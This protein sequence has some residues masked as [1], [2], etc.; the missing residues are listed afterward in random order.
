MAATTATS[1]VPE[2]SLVLDVANLGAATPVEVDTV[3]AWTYA[4]YYEVLDR[5]DHHRRYADD[6]RTR[7]N[8]VDA[9]TYR[10]A[11][12]SADRERDEVGLAKQD[13]VIAELTAQ[14]QAV[15][16]EAVPYEAEYERRGRWTRAFLVQ[17]SNG[18]V[19][20][21]RS[22]S[23][24]YPTTRYHWIL[25]FSGSTEQDVVAA[26]RASA[27]TECYP[28]APVDLRSQPSLIE[29]P[30]KAAARA[31]RAQAKAVRDAAAA[32]KAIANPDGSTLKTSYG[33]I[34]TERTAE[35]EYVSTAADIR[36]WQPWMNQE[37]L[38]RRQ[39]DAQRILEALAHKRGTTTAQQE[40]ALAPKVEKKV[41][42]SNR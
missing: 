10:Y 17:N 33:T 21:S 3:L 30:V 24:C 35:I 27:C 1:K 36:G 41:R 7:L 37:S 5:V 32:A 25:E 40:Q 15:L 14:A 2:L 26:A 11:Y 29:D 31:E 28:S 23:T 20:S 8:A 16:D 38:V 19:H 18:H 22:C 34:R 12:S 9:G 6:Y 4:R 39:T 42:A 13:A